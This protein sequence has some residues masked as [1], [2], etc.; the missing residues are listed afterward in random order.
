ML[1]KLKRE[2]WQANL[3]LV[4]YNLVI[5]TWGNVSGIDRKRGLVV[6][7]PSGVPYEE[8]KPEHMVVVD[9]QGKVIEGKLRPSSDTPTHLWL[10]KAWP[11]I[12]GVT[13]THSTYATMFAQA[14]R[15]LP[16]LGTTHADYFSGDVPVTRSLTKKEVEQD[17]EGNTGKVII[18]R[19]S[20]IKPEDITAV[21]AANHGP[22]AWGKSPMDSVKNS[23]ALEE[24]A[25]MAHGT[26]T[27]NPRTTSL[28]AHILAKHWKRRHGPKATYGQSK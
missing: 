12:G 21:L 5:L 7:K 17:Y 23:L 28:P 11:G 26:L 10:Y 18:Q 20:R 8:M 22:F 1:E 6:I 19:F 4:K 25:R 24:V 27:L 9:L 2:V 16:C 15:P 13:H 3:A 14:Q